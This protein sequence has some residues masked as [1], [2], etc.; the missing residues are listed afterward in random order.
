M[1][2][3][4][5]VKQLYGLRDDICIQGWEPTD[6]E[7]HAPPTFIRDRQTKN[8]LES[9]LE[10]IAERLPKS[11]DY[12]EED[13][14]PLEEALK[15]FES[16]CNQLAAYPGEISALKVK[17]L[18]KESYQK[19]KDKTLFNEYNNAGDLSSKDNVKLFLQLFALSVQWLNSLISSTVYHRVNESDAKEIEQN[20]VRRNASLCAEIQKQ[21]AEGRR[22]FVIAGSLHLLNHDDSH[23]AQPTDVQEE[24]HRHPFVIFTPTHKLNKLSLGTLKQ[25]PVR[26]T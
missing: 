14:L 24:L 5:S 15:A 4:D 8:A 23:M 7:K 20:I 3:E 19:L 21:R 2:T 1:S 16:I 9:T 26:V 18:V 25:Q 17:E 22:V 6:F 12:C 10:N 13:L 11:V